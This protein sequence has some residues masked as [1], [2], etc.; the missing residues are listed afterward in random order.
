MIRR[1]VAWIAR[2]AVALLYRRI[3]VAGLERFPEG[4]PVLLVA[5]HANAFIDPVVITAALGRTPRFIAKETLSRIPV[6]GWLLRRVGVV[7]V[8]RRSDLGGASADNESSFVECHRAL[9]AGDVVAIFPEGTSSDRVRVEPIKTGAARIALGAR[10]AG[11]TGL[12]IVPVGMAFPDKVALR[13]SAL[14]QFGTPVDLDA[15]VA[16]PTGPDDR[17]AVEALTDDIDAGLRAVS[18]DFDDVEDALA[19]EQAALLALSGP[20]RPDPPLV[21]RADL[22]RRLAAVD[23]QDQATIA[24]EVGRYS[25]MLRGLH[26][27]DG[28]VITPTNPV[29]LVRSAAGIGVLVVVLGGLVAATIVVNLW[30]AL[31]AMSSGLVV[32]A[33]FLKGTAR[34]LVGMLAF[35]TAWIIGAVLTADGFLLCS[36]FAATFAAGALAA[37]LL[38]ERSVTLALMLL[39][40]QAQRERVATI[41]WVEPVRAEV[42][43]RI[44]ATVPDYLTPMSQ[45]LPDG[46]ERGTHAAK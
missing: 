41:E 22:A 30:P 29:R 14:I 32:R 10:R 34:L 45:K 43:D 36:L 3:E 39:R 2:F 28:D 13:S 16:A 5:N 7:F 38:V 44:L 46:Q 6:A 31:L 24:R 18:P 1:L 8:H 12:V 21:E 26:L 17:A 15:R 42:V 19:C 9:A 27:T 33:P 25:T 23:R 40:W 35:P 20:D 37:V 4:R 11:A